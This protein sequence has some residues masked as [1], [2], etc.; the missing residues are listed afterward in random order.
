MIRLEIL[1]KPIMEVCKMKCDNRLHEKLDKF[2]VTKYLNKHQTS[3]FLGSPGSG[4]TSLIIA[5]FENKLLL[6]RVFDQ[7]FIFQPESSR[8]SM[9]NELFAKLPNNQV[10]DELS[11]ENLTN[12]MNT[13]ESNLKAD[14]NMNFCLIFD[15]MQSYLKDN[16]L[17]KQLR[18]LVA[19][20]RHLH[21]SIFFLC[22]SYKTIA[23]QIRKLFTNL[24]IFKISPIEFEAVNSELINLNKE[25]CKAVRNMVF[26]KKHEYLFVNTDN[27]R[28]FKR[29]DE[30]ILLE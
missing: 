29:F 19:N 9:D 16:V 10:F 5:L 20:R 14:S 26:D 12:V 13:I 17:Q 28:L 15:D 7:I 18:I 21:V 22:Q 4:K 25:Q 27:R 3:L 24:F 2:E 30:I 8:F 1:N 6:N 11:L 23:V